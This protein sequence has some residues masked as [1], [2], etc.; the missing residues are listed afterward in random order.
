MELNSKITGQG[1]D[2]MSEPIE[3][4]LNF[5]RYMEIGQLALA[6]GQ[7]DEAL[8]NFEAAYNLQ[9]DFLANRS[10]VTVL[11]AQSEFFEAKKIADEMKLDYLSDPKNFTLYVTILTGTHFFI[12]GRKL[13]RRCPFSEKV[14]K[15]CLEELEQGEQFFRKFHGKELTKRLSLATDLSDLPFYQQG[16][17]LRGLER[18]PLE[19][20]V[21][22]VKKLIEQA[23]L[24]LL[25]NN[26]LVEAL[27]EL[28]CQFELLSQ[29]LMGPQLIQLGELSLINQQ[30]SYLSSLNELQLQVENSDSELS[31]SLR[32][33]LRLQFILLYPLGDQLIQEPKLWVSLFLAS[34]FGNQVV[35]IPVDEAYL[36]LQS[37]L[38]QELARL[39]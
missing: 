7:L 28:G 13:V 17:R 30:D 19:E 6:E 21:N 18:L 27:V 11:M 31:R 5:D 34:Y 1:S 26:G 2:D 25:L 39:A 35:E 24:P 20:Y 23:G 16:N 14:K 12:Q 29:S 15:S 32:E 22:L 37:R 36:T 9:E 4:P 33:E 3:F 10:L 8:L 38:R